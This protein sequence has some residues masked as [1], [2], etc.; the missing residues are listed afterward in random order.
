MKAD[1]AQN[2]AYYSKASA[3]LKKQFDASHDK[4]RKELYER[5]VEDHA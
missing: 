2:Q 5:I 1:D 3:D 4:W